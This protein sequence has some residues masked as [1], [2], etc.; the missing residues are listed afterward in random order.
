VTATEGTSALRLSPLES[1]RFGLRV[2]RASTDTIDA[3]ALAEAMAR[4]RIDVAILRIPARS[5]ASVQS[6]V[7]LGFAPIVADTLVQY[8]ISLDSIGARPE[9]ESPVTLRAA[10]RADATLLD[11]MARAIFA[12]YASHYH[13]NPLFAHDLIL[14]GY[15]EW[16]TR[17]IEATDASAAW[18]VEHDGTPVG[19]S[20]DRWTGNGGSA[21]GVLNGILPDARRRGFYGAMLQGVLCRFARSG[22]GRFAIATQVHNLAVQRTWIANGFMLESAYNTIHVNAAR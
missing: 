22:A 15:A 8:D 6:L 19:F 16:A 3:A 20:C 1:A 5:L 18:I 2:F 11:Q 14:D 4:D 10:T 21:I 12:G 7:P 17:H 9:R 13:A